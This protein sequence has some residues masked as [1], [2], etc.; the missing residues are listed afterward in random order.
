MTEAPPTL[1]VHSDGCFFP[2][3]VK[4]VHSL[5]TGPK[6]MVWSD[7]TQIDFY[8]QPELVEKA[9]GAA[10]PH[11]STTSQA[12]SD[13]LPALVRPVGLLRDSK[14]SS[15]AAEPGVRPHRKS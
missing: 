4:R 12:Y 7:G 3:H 14:G 13:L 5:L 9:I 6:D 15:A 2:D 8:D 10:H 1:F 11:F